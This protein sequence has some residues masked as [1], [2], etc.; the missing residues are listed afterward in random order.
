MDLGVGSFVFSLGVV[1]SLPLLRQ[2]DQR[3]YLKS[4]LSSIKKAL[5]IIGLGCIRVIMVKGVEYP[6][7]TKKNI[8]FFDDSPRTE[9]RSLQR[10]TS[11]NMVF[12][13][14]FSSRWRLFLSLAL[15]SNVS[16]VCWTF[17]GSVYSFQSVQ[18]EFVAFS[19]PRDDRAQL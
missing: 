9:P 18:L 19:L 16:L 15:R 11:Q 1:S 5:P 14:T 17:T 2:T 4:V 8:I 3:P 12:T 6:V 13:G 10:S 7:S